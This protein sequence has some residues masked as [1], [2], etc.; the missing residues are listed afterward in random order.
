MNPRIISIDLAKN[1]FQLCA[2]DTNNKVLFNR[3]IK[4]AKLMDTLRSFEPSVVCMEACASANYWGRHCQAL[5]HEVKIIPA[6][7]VKAFVRGGKTDRNDAL[8]IA[9]AAQRPKLHCLSPK[10]VE[11]QDIQAVL[12]VRSRLVRQRTAVANQLRGVAREYGVNFAMGYRTLLGQVADALED[13]SNELSAVARHIIA[14]LVD[15]LH[16]LNTRI[17][18]A[19]HQLLELTAHNEASQRLQSAPGFGPLVAGTLLGAV[20]NASQFKNGRQ[21]AAWVGLVPRRHGTGGKVTLYGITKA[22]DRELRTMLV[23]GARA[24]VTWAHRRDDALGR[25]VTQLK[26][27]V[28]VHKAIVAMANK[29][30]RIAWAILT[31][32]DS[33][34]IDKAFAA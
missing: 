17:E 7:H 1:V 11:Q 26:A 2:L 21:L 32:G 5:G 18:Q 6:Q 30:A 9:E 22:G 15:E 4:R 24:V 16:G 23:H 34:D 29:M 10:S 27:R 14:S 20:G 12:R 31:K 8:A 3:S 19:K 13:A 25:W 28:G 33:F